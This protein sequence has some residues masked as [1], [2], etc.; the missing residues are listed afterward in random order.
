MTTDT[1]SKPTLD[2]KRVLV[3]DLFVTKIISVI[4]NL[5]LM[6]IILIL[7]AVLIVKLMLML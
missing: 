5:F 3:K 2:L 6:N 1:N 4:L 7:L